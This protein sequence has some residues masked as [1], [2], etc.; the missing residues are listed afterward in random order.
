MERAYL[1]LVAGMQIANKTDKGFIFF[2]IY[3]QV[4]KKKKF[5][6][7]LPIQYM[8]LREPVKLSY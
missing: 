2:L 5:S 7:V 3:A 8:H 6:L 4:K 1:I